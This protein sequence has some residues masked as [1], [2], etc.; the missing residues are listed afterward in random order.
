MRTTLNPAC[1]MMAISL[2][3][4]L[5]RAIDGLITRAHE[6]LPG[7]GPIGVRRSVLCSCKQAQR[8]DED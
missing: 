1:F 2:I 7:A 8:T 6:E 5:G 3:D 4:L